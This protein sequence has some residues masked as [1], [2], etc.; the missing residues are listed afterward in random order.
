M[1][2]K[3]KCKSQNRNR[4]ITHGTAALCGLLLLCLPT[5]IGA[6]ERVSKPGQYQGYS[7]A[8]FDGWN[9]TSRYISMRDGTKIAVDIFRPTS[10]GTLHADPLPVVWEHRRYQ[11][12]SIDPSG[13]ILSQLDRPDHPMRKLP[14][15][16]Y[17]FAV[18]DV[19]GSGASFGSRV[20]PTP[21]QES[22]DAYDITEWL[23]GQPWC[24]GRVGMYGISYAGSAQFM[25]ASV[26][27]P[28]LKAIFP[29]MAMFDL[30]DLCY[31]GGIYRH[32]LMRGW[33]QQVRTLDLSQAQRAAPVDEDRDQRLLADAMRQHQGNFD[34]SRAA[35]AAFRD[36]A[37]PQVGRVYIENSPS[38]YIEDVNK[39]GVAIYQ[40]AGWF[41]M[42][43]RD[44]LLWH[45][46]LR[47]PRKIAI[48]PWDHYQSHGL[49]R[50]T[51]MLRW[52]DYW[53]KGIDNG[54]MNEPPILYYVM[55]A[56]A[57]KALR[58]ASQ[59]PIPEAQSVNYHFTDGPSGSVQS[60]NDGLLSPSAGKSGSDPYTVDYTTTSGPRT[61]WTGGPTGYTDMTTND[62]KALTYT[63]EPL[64]Q[65]VE[66][67][68]HPVVH[69]WLQ[70]AA[71]DIDVFAYLEEIDSQGR[72]YY[73]TE[74]CLRASHRTL[75][76]APFACMDLP[77]H[78][79]SQKD[80][81]RL[82]NEPTELV[83]DLLPTA[84][85]FPAGHRIRIAVTGADK[86]NY[87]TP[88]RKP[89]PIL[90]ILRDTQ[91]PSHV[92]LPVVSD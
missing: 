72:S 39:S 92:V 79:C 64:A 34:V 78:P 28:H 5:G 27:P 3:P 29:E 37:I 18:A 69:V 50:G 8:A 49:D 51:E 87:Q 43:P 55:G 65:P 33:Q 15:H 4:R 1:A 54:I 47:N 11:R 17:I 59:W 82:T 73:I 42:Y 89:A 35:Q 58:Q 90:T 44:M 26:Q 85:H 57:D 21:S 13:R 6:E 84:K 76:K 60:I 41:D 70:S 91:H 88:Q 63:T 38:S 71:E 46:N 45:S 24:S 16:G 74:G 31:P 22:L 9:R 14:P 80:V 77:Y 83:F 48:G 66:I 67:V 7:E 32:T 40:R 86:D 56:P 53:L 62:C 25:A 81:K 61:R 23:A 19:R 52:F 2:Y 30:Y 12:A 68:G 20:D 36:S 75:A 10:Q